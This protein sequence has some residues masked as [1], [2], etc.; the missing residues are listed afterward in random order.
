[1]PCWPRVHSS[2]QAARATASLVAS[3]WRT[4]HR[5]ASI[6]DHHCFSTGLS[7]KFLNFLGIVNP[8]GTSHVVRGYFCNHMANANLFNAI[9]S[10]CL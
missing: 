3:L 9:S 1:M 5:K 4:A 7:L 10:L 8:R 2:K 6:H